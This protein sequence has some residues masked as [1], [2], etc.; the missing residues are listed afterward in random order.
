MMTEMLGSVS[1]DDL[2]LGFVSEDGL[3]VGVCQ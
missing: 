3:N 1:D 2:N